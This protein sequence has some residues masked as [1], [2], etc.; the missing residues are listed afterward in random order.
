MPM[1]RGL[2]LIQVVLHTLQ[3]ES[4]QAR[5]V[6]KFI[7]QKNP[8]ISVDLVTPLH[9]LFFIFDGVNG[10]KLLRKEM[11]QMSLILSFLSFL[12]LFLEKKRQLLF[13]L[14]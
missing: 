1:Q 7:E 3:M 11:I 14:S 12:V 6:C 5:T 13:F 2:D 4:K 8:T 10:E 9:Y